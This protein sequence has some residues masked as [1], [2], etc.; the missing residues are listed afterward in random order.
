VP[1]TLHLQ[2][3]SSYPIGTFRVNE[4]GTLDA[5]ETVDQSPDGW[6]GIFQNNAWL[7]VVVERGEVVPLR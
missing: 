5:W 1:F 3:G 7:S 6:F 4:D 2:N